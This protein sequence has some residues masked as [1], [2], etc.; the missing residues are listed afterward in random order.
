MVAKYKSVNILSDLEVEEKMEMGLCF[1][2]DEP[3]TMEHQLLCKNIR[4]FM[5][6]DEDEGE[7]EHEA[8]QQ[9]VGDLAANNAEEP[10]T[11]LHEEVHGIAE[12]SL[13]VS[14]CN[15]QTPKSTSTST[16]MNME[17]PTDSTHVFFDTLMSCDGDIEQSQV[18]DN[19]V[20]NLVSE[21]KS[22]D[23]DSS[24]VI[25]GNA[26]LTTPLQVFDQMPMKWLNSTSVNQQPSTISS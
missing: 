14:I 1:L 11:E 6:D 23:N 19:T 15:S 17:K 8:L 20:T 12:D 16:D 7:P 13:C 26:V 24:F 9:Q 18:E 10:H 2:C 22:T 21:M 5:M 25:D 3:F 4:I